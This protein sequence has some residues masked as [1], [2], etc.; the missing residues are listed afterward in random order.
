MTGDTKTMTTLRCGSLRRY[1][2]NTTTQPNAGSP[3]RLMA[4][5]QESPELA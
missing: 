5:D 3:S 4:A 2:S 1:R